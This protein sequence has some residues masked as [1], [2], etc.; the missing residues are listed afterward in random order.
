MRG[1][2]VATASWRQ[3]HAVTAVV[4]RQ[5]WRREAVWRRSPRRT[6]APNASEPLC[7]PDR[8]GERVSERNAQNPTEAGAVMGAGAAGHPVFLP[9]EICVGPPSGRPEG[10]NDDG[11]TP[12]QKSDSFIVATKLVKASRAKEG[13]D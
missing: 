13:M 8:P 1:E 10:G 2:L 7:K 5:S 6:A 12:M 9:R 11:T 3:L 4:R